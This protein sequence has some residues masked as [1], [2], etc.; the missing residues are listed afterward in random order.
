MWD[1][2]FHLYYHRPLYYGC[3]NIHMQ[4]KESLFHCDRIISTYNPHVIYPGW[5]LIHQCY[6][7]L[8]ST[9]LVKLN[10]PYFMCVSVLWVVTNIWLWISNVLNV[11]V[12][13]V[14]SQWSYVFSQKKYIT[15]WIRTDA[16][17][18]RPMFSQS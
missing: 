6:F 4:V 8:F 18:S 3:C 13:M 7:V 5:S 10:I 14:S 11:T 2:Y 12:H 17:S 1:N 15:L 9:I 16:L